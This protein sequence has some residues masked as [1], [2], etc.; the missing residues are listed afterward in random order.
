MWTGGISPPSETE[1]ERMVRNY[2]TG[3]VALAAL[4]SVAMAS[5]GNAATVVQVITPISQSIG[6]LTPFDIN[7]LPFNPSLGVLTGVSV[8]LIGHYTPITAT[9]SDGT[10]PF[11]GTAT[12]TTRLFV[13]ATNGGPTSSLV[14]GSVLL[15]VVVASPNSAGISTGTSTAVDQLFSLS[16][17]S[18]FETAIPG[19]QLLVEYGFKTA[20]SLS[21][22]HFSSGSDLTTFTGEAILT[23]TYAVPEPASV[24]VLASGLL[25]LAWSRR[26]PA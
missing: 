11:P 13:F 24:L 7:A 6:D 8:E 2:V 18:S 20:T 17:L 23:Y 10:L 9:D 15:P 25:G 16:F 5:P 26:R 1:Q 4:A 19:P 3:I 14:L 22:P 12:L 21:G